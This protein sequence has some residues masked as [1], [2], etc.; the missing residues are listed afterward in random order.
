[1]SL[2]SGSGSSSNMGTIRFH[3]MRQGQTLESVAS[4]YQ[5]DVSDILKN[6]PEASGQTGDM[7][8]LY[9]NQNAPLC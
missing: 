9:P 3:Q 6:N 1:M 2:M 5:I 7:L 4:D 8:V